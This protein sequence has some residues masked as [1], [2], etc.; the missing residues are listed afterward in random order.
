MTSASSH[1]LAGLKAGDGVA[2]N[3][4]E[5]GDQG[6]RDLGLTFVIPEGEGRTVDLERGDLAEGSEVLLLALHYVVRACHERGGD[7][8]DR[9]LVG[10]AGAEVGRVS[11]AA[12]RAEAKV[13]G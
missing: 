11:V 4:R 12:S 9:D 8:P 10:S 2:G 3:A 6:E 13:G 5:S 7:D 1:V